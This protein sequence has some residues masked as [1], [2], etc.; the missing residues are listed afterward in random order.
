MMENIKREFR[1]RGFFY[2]LLIVG[3]KSVIYE[4]YSGREIVSYEIHKLYFRKPREFKGR[5]YYTTNRFPGDEDFGK[6]AWSIRN[7]D[8][9]FQK[10]EALEKRSKSELSLLS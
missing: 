3:K 9:A 6:W 2:K 10:F 1:K 7:K 8:R 4:Q 5:I